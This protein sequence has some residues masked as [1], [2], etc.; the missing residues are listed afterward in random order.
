[1]GYVD[2]MVYLSLVFFCGASFTLFFYTL[3]VD[4]YGDGVCLVG[5][6]GGENKGEGK[7]KQ[8]GGRL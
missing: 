8:R 2:M 1:M 5:W 4:D 3:M 6:W 7:G